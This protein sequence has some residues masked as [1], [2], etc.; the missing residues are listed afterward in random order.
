MNIKRTL[1]SMAASAGFALMLTSAAHASVGPHICGCLGP[2]D[3]VTPVISQTAGIP[4][5]AIGLGV[6]ATYCVLDN[7]L[8]LGGACRGD[9]GG[10][11]HYIITC[12]GNNKYDV[13]LAV[14]DE[15]GTRTFVRETKILNDL[16]FAQVNDFIKVMGAATGLNLDNFASADQATAGTR[17]G[18][19]VYSV[20]FAGKWEPL[21]TG[22]EDSKA[23]YAYG[24][25]INI[26]QDIVG[27]A[28]FIGA[29]NRIAV[30][31]YD[32]AVVDVRTAQAG[33]MR[34]GKPDQALRIQPTTQT[35]YEDTR[36]RALRLR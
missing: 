27:T 8:G 26:I 1:R 17:G 13:S 16:S 11:A 6:V 34:Y 10:Q 18:R 28:R 30:S 33:S 5:W 32:T 14:T 25:T 19:I 9:H 20:G 23:A 4:S 36:G 22:H 7:T 29:G 15:R 31:G 35:Q 2:V 24:A 21:L 3:P 12:D